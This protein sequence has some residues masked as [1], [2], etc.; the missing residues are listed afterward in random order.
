MSVDESGLGQALSDEILERRS[1]LPLKP[2]P[3]TLTG[4]TVRLTPPDLEHDLAPLHSVSNGQPIDWGDRRADGFDADALIWRYMTGGPF[5]GEEDLAAWL[6]SQIESPNGLCLCVHDL[7]ANRPIGTVGIINNSPSDLKVE[8][9]H[10]WYSPVAQRTAANTESVAML[11]QHVF[12]L[13]YRRVEWK[14][15][16]LN[17]RSRQAALRLGFTFEGI[18]QYHYIIKGRSRDTAWFRILD[19]EWP[20][21]KAL[22][23]KL[24]TRS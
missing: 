15:H 14:C 10:I 21:V 16:A 5:S 3:V 12:E 6:R 17:E 1:K 11:L 13:G 7:A 18:Q 9:G 4:R 23:D 8:L 19:H 24:L 22:L 2:A 20:R